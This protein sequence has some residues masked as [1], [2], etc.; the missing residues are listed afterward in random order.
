MN[1][2]IDTSIWIDRTR[3]NIPDRRRDLARIQL[4]EEPACL[5]QAVQFELL[6]NATKAEAKML[7]RYFAEFPMLADPEDLWERATNLSQACR[8]NG[9]TAGAMDVLIATVAIYHDS[10]LV[11][12]DTDFLRVAEV[13]PLRVIKLDRPA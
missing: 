1:R 9:N 6:R 7:E 4:E 3:V 10:E 2:L 11:T 12:Y 5:C 13:S 8:S